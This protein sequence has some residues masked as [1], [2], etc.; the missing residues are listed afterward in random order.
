MSAV[1]VPG[2]KDPSLGSRRYHLATILAV[3]MR[4]GPVA[5]RGS[6]RGEDRAPRPH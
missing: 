6:H 2:R 1:L 5:S 4:P 3:G